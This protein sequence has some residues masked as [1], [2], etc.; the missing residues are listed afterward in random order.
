MIK[1]KT[2][3]PSIDGLDESI[4]NFCADKKIISI[5]VF[6]FNGYGNSPVRAYIVY[7]ELKK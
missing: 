4:N 3:Y 7:K 2:I 6:D 1:F 5:Q